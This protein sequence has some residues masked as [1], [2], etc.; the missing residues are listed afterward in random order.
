MPTG[1]SDQPKVS[2]II[3]AYN[4]APY[5]AETLQS[6]FAQSFTDYELIVVDDGSTDGTERAIESFFDRL[7]YVRQKNAGPSAA[8]NTGLKQARGRYV[9]LLDGDDLWLPNYLE[10]MVG[11]M[12]ANPDLDLIYP[13]A[14]IFG[15]SPNNGRLFFDLHPSSE[16]VT[17]EKVVKKE[18][19]VMVSCLFK[20]ELIDQVGGFDLQFRG[21]EDFDLWLRMLHHGCRFSFTT[22]PLV[23]Y[24]R[25]SASLS[26]DI[27][28]LEK[29]VITVYEKLLADPSLTQ[30]ERDEINFMIEKTEA[31]IS[32]DMAKDLFS[33]RDYAGAVE[34]FKRSDKYY[35]NWK[36]RAAT[37]VL[38]TAPGV[39]TLVEYFRN[40]LDSRRRA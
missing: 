26:S 21:V 4:V 32:F 3:P 39:L 29:K 15:D 19:V 10:E 8:R 38:R 36:T 25:H 22:E 28:N 31:K 9:A 20:R 40:W 18:C 17:F 7:I 23:R 1:H 12:E 5:I 35:G 13:N 37:V 2:I 24:R 30:S 6:V 27:I 33:K 34:H 14:I 16:P 11:R